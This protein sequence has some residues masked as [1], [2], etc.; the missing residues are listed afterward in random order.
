[1]GKVQIRYNTNNLARIANKDSQTLQWY[2]DVALPQNTFTLLDV[3]RVKLNA[4]QEGN[5]FLYRTQFAWSELRFCLD[6]SGSSP[7]GLAAPL[8]PPPGKYFS[9]LPLPR[10]LCSRWDAFVSTKSP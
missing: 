2:L 7:G 5:L 3:C 4:R 6:G 10:S 8:H 1:M 9:A